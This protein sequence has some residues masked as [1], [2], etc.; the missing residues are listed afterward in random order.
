MTIGEDILN[1]TQQRAMRNI[2]ARRRKP[3]TAEERQ[4]AKQSWDQSYLGGIVNKWEIFSKELLTPVLAGEGSFL[5][6]D[7]TGLKIT[8][9]KA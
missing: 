2:S 5:Y 8:P 3:M 6:N 1:E 4:R 7:A 9:S